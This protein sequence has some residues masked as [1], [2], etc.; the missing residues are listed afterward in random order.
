MQTLPPTQDQRIVQSGRTWEQFKLIQEGFSNAP[1]VRLF[2]FD[3]TIEVLMP[4]REHELFSAV[5]ALLLGLFF[6]ERE[7][8][9]EPTGSMDQ[10]KLGEAFVQADQS[11]CFGESQSGESKA[12]PDLSI[13][14]VV[15]SGGINK[16]ARYR[17]LGVPEVWFW[18]DGAFRLFHLRET[19]YEPVSRSE[20]PQLETLDIALLTQCV[21]MGK[22]SRLDAA[23]AFQ[24]GIRRASFQ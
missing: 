4:G 19:G 1:G 18:E 21:L 16:L 24:Q 13:E 5:I 22:T 15:S 8:E 7:I 12:I 10:E 14:V 3:G 20:L 11:Y 23:R 17:A 9:F 2:Y 6:L